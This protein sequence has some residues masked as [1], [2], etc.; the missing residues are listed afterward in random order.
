M[1][2]LSIA[3]SFSAEEYDEDDALNGMALDLELD[4]IEE[5][6]PLYQRARI[7][8]TRIKTTACCFGT[9]VLLSL[10]CGIIFA[11]AAFGPPE[12]RTSPIFIVAE[13]VINF[14]LVLEVAS[15]ILTQGRDY[16]QNLSNLVDFV[17]TLA[18]AAFFF[19]FLEENDEERAN[20]DDTL[21]LNAILLGI[22]YFFQLFRIMLCA[23]RGHST[24]QILAQDEVIF[25][26]PRLDV[27][28]I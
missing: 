27:P 16:F 6:V 25:P 2:E 12:F 18:C 14:L 10:I 24:A 20:G 5:D 1:Q 9:Y 7:V 22:R 13:A 8:V 4:A 21:P 17:V 28:V 23:V 3:G 26:R 19:T 15:D 11:A